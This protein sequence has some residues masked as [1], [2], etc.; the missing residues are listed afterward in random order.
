MHTSSQE[1]GKT[2]G[3][4]VMPRMWSCPSGCSYPNAHCSWFSSLYAV[5]ACCFDSLLC[6]FRWWS[7]L[8]VLARACW[9][10]TPCPAIQN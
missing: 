4:T 3:R 5:V 1:H 2:G 8:C 7:L 6:F 9:W 10:I